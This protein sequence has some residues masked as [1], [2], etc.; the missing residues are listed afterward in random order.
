MASEKAPIRIDMNAATISPTSVSPLKSSVL[1]SVRNTTQK[2]S[3]SHVPLRIV[4]KIE[5]PKIKS[6]KQS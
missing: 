5:M 3:S 4:S 1:K 2:T 6:T